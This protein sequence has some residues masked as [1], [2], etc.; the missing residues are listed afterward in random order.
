MSLVL[1]EA[2]AYVHVPLVWWAMR[3]FARR[4]V[5]GEIAAGTLLGFYI[6][7]A[8][9]PLWDYHFAIN[10]YKDAPLAVPL[11]WGAMFAL[12]TFL[13]EKLLRRLHPEAPLERAD[14]RMLL[15]DA[16]AGFLIG[17]PLEWIGLRSGVWRYNAEILGWDWGAVPGLGFP[18][19]ALLGYILL[20][21][22]APSFV[23]YWRRELALPLGA[24]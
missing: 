10:F 4:E 11:G 2:W 6:E 17:V 14:R 20:M 9:E 19:E 23:R 13:S 12:V 3:R 5:S 18:Y 1:W 8:T 24:P 21:L 15:C 22:V 7:F 16:A